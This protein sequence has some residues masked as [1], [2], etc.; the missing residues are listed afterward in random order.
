[1][2]SVV[3][4]SKSPSRQAV[5][6]AAGVAFEAL[7]SGVDED[8]VKIQLLRD[9]LGPREIALRLA[10]AKAV[11]VSQA[12]PGAIVIGADQ[13]LDLG[14]SLFDKA[15]TLAEARARL[16]QLRGKPHLLHSAVA[17]AQ[18]GAV[19]WRLLES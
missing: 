3:L 8:R 2:T 10:E 14:G 17:A 18:D 11:S 4:A 6:R 12:R 16:Q 1:M 15:N 5:L 13:T 19:I 9:G 7:G